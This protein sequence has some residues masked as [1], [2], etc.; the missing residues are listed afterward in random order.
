MCAVARSLVI[1]IMVVILQQRVEWPLWGA[2]E[3]HGWP[4]V[5]SGQGDTDPVAGRAAR[6]GQTSGPDGL[7][8]FPRAQDGRRTGQG[9]EEATRSRRGGMEEACALAS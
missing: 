5:G 9:M 7:K 1:S 4:P 6:S 2:P 8:L 3:S